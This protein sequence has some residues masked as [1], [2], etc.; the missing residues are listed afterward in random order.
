MPLNTNKHFCSQFN[1][2]VYNICISCKNFNEEDFVTEAVEKSP[3]PITIIY[4][5]TMS[6]G[7]LE[8]HCFNSNVK[9]IYH[10]IS[11]QNKVFH[12]KIESFFSR[13]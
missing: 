4:F 1:R 9:A 10:I 11:T 12:F 7:L 3:I 8:N 2:G 13:I 6:S 5:N